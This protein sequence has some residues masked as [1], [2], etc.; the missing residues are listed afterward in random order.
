MEFMSLSYRRSSSRNV[1]SGEERGETDVFAGYPTSRRL[2]SREF[3]HFPV[4]SLPMLSL[5]TRAFYLNTY[6]G[7]R[8][9]ALAGGP[10]FRSGNTFIRIQ[11]KTVSNKPYIWVKFI[12]HIIVGSDL[13]PPPRGFS[14]R[15]YAVSV[16]QNCKTYKALRINYITCNKEIHELLIQ[17]GQVNCIF[18]NKQ[19][20]DPG[21]RDISAAI[22]WD[23]S[24]T[25]LS[26]VRI[27]LSPW[28]ILRS[29]IFWFLWESP[30]D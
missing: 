15:Q 2:S 17:E 14:L 6:K 28:W 11:P 30:Q 21:K 8:L 9:P 3:P 4:F 5:K 18:C 20:Q 7:I 22:L 26:C 1:P 12:I 24:K 19:I 10:R 13:C 16:G 27:A 23:W 25:V 29:R